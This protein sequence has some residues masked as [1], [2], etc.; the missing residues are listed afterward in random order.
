MWSNWKRLKLENWSTWSKARKDLTKISEDWRLLL[1]IDGKRWFKSTKE[2]LYPLHSNKKI[3]RR[4]SNLKFPKLFNPFNNKLNNLLLVKKWRKLAVSKYY[5][6]WNLLRSRRRIN[7]LQFWKISLS[8]L[9]IIRKQFLFLRKKIVL[10]RSAT[11]KVAKT[12][13]QIRIH[14]TQKCVL[15]KICSIVASGHNRMNWQSS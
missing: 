6:S 11:S 4:L 2:L 13:T 8:Q 14:P 3:S 5:D 7:L 12:Y 10:F 1:W 9:Q 15:V